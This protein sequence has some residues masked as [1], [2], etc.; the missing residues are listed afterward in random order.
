[1]T[2]PCGHGSARGSSAPSTFVSHFCV[3]RPVENIFGYNA[4]ESKVA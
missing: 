2:A 4:Q 1:M 3:A